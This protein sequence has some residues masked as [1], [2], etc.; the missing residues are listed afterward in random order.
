[1]RSTSGVASGPVSFMELFDHMTE[2]VKQGETRRGANMGILGASHP[3]IIDFVKAK[4]EGGKLTNFNISVGIPDA[5]ME[6]LRA[7]AN[8]DLVNPRTSSTLGSPPKT[9]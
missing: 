1:M 3:D 7:E 2:V 9:R 6:A 5:F 4:T 8:W